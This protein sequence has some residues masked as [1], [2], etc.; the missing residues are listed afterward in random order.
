[1]GKPYYYLTDQMKQDLAFSPSVN[2]SKGIY[3][4][5]TSISK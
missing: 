4:Y 5:I 2:F 1:V 3:E